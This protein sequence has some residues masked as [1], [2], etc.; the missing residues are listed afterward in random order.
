MVHLKTK[1]G[2]PGRHPPSLGGVDV[3]ST[4]WCFYHTTPPGERSNVK[5]QL[6]DA[7]SR[8]HSQKVKE[9]YIN[10]KLEAVFIDTVDA[11]LDEVDEEN[12]FLLELGVP[13]A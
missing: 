3:T 6:H 9:R 11:I 4:Q 2:N 1:A 10:A 5:N 13:E 7:V 8:I 12:E